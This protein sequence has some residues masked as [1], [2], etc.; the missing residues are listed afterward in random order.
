MTQGRRRWLLLGVIAALT[1]M[2][3]LAQSLDPTPADD[4]AAQPAPAEPDESAETQNQQ[5]PAASEP[6]TDQPTEPQP[7]EPAP[8]EPAAAQPEPAPAAPTE[9]ARAEAPPDPAQKYGLW[10]ALPAGIAI[11]L[12]IAVRQVIP[13]LIVGIFVGAAMMVPCLAADHAYAHQNAIL[14]TVRLAAEQ[15]IFGEIVDPETSHAHM[16]VI[17]FTLVI[18]FCVG[19]IGRSGGTAGMVNLV[20]G[21]TASQRR[22]GITAWLAGLIVFFDDY[23]NCMIIGPTMQPVFDRLRM[24]RA[25]LAYIVDSTAAPVAS[26]ALIGT[27]VGAE[28]GYIQKGFD[29]LPADQMPEFLQGVTA[30]GAFLN[31]L[32]YRFYAI[33]TLVLVFLLVLMNRDFGPMRRSQQR[34]LTEDPPGSIA[35]GTHVAPGQ[36]PV[37]PRWALGLVPILVL[38][39]VTVGILALTGVRSEALAEK[40]AD[41][42]AWQATPWWK[43]A[44]D[45]L[46]NADSYLSIFYG[47]FAT[48]AVAVVLA[49]LARACTIREAFDA[50][51]D[52]MARVFPAIV[53]LVLAWSLSQVSQDLKLGDVASAELQAQQFS[54][55][56]MSLAVFICAALISFATGTSWGTMGILCP[57]TVTVTARLIAQEGLPA[58]QAQLAFYGAV[59]SVLAGSVFGD[60][61]SPISDTTVLSAIASGCSLEEHVWTQLPYALVTAVV[62][63]GVG[64]VLVSRFHQPWW[65]GLGAGF[66]ILLLIVLIVGRK[67]R[68]PTTARPAQTLSPIQRH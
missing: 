8:T 23:A 37:K 26:I 45:V 66:I 11:L 64:D 34:A 22:G 40:M 52:G 17:V 15:Y 49:M 59:G 47:A 13:A 54:A 7:A 57:I 2:P 38:I 56:W 53:I 60:H 19:V 14:A 31:S 10:V 48:A 33:L 44:S 28:I 62:S 6:Q 29:A 68:L 12:A 36:Q 16:K 25:K 21:N 51:V 35:A 39:G 50:G 9:A 20:A 18:G 41:A 30:M 3:L 1:A 65:Y 32:P 67:P 5:E 43:K 42:P 24:S 61:C 63:M 27:W 55:H 46:S 4:A 58:D